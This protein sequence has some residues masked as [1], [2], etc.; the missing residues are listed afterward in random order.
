MLKYSAIISLLVLFL[1]VSYFNITGQKNFDS[2]QTLNSESGLTVSFQP[3]PVVPE[4]E[5]QVVFQL[6]PS[7]VLENSSEHIIEGWVEGLNMYMGKTP[8]LLNND[9]SERTVKGVMFLGSCSEPTM[10]W[11]ITLRIR[12]H[13]HVVYSGSAEFTTQQ[14]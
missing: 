4:E 5:I 2:E 12:H 11:R 13:E 14:Y 8:I 7:V 9:V 10:R 3:S 6:P 1:A